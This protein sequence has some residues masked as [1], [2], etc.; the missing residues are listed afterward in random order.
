M[1]LDD[2]LFMAVLGHFIVD[3][4]RPAIGPKDFDVTAKLV[5]ELIGILNE[6]VIGVMLGF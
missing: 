1:F 4:F 2:A 6:V 5:A 3:E